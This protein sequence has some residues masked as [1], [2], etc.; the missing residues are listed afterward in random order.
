MRKLLITAI[1]TAAFA[2][3]FA[4]HAKTLRIENKRA[5]ALTELTIVPKDKVKEGEASIVLVKNIPPK[6]VTS[7]SVPKAGCI[8]DVKGAFADQSTVTAQDMNLCGQHTIRLTE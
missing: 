4:V 5:V 2:A 7:R 1:A 3:P 8:F 6:A